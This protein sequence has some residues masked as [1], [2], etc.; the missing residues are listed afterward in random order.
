MNLDKE[1]VQMLMANNCLGTTGLGE[2]AGVHAQ[3]IRNAIKGNKI[4]L[5]TAGKIARALSVKVEDI[6]KQD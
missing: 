6:I 2:K 3:T 5:V 4:N 1:K